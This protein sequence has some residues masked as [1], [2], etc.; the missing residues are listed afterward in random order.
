MKKFLFLFMLL[1]EITFVQA[2]RK[3]TVIYGGAG[4]SLFNVV[5]SLD[6]LDEIK[7]TPVFYG[8]ADFRMD[9]Y[10][11]IG[12]SYAFQSISLTDPNFVGS[13]ANAPFVAFYRNNIGFRSLLHMPIELDWL[14]VYLGFRVSYTYYQFRTNVNISPNT[15][16]DFDMHDYNQQGLLGFRFNFTSK[17]GLQLEGAIGAPYFAAAGLHYKLK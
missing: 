2:Q 5:G 11:S 10:F 4:I 15:M 13:P 12:A 14:E 17:F 9:K 7:Y 1:L 16:A 8:G 6:T 3:E